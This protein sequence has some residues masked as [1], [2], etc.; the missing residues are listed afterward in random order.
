MIK[1]THL[2]THCITFDRKAGWEMKILQSWQ[3]LIRI[4][5]C[6][7]FVGLYLFLMDQNTSI[8]SHFI[9]FWGSNQYFKKCMM[10]LWRTAK[11]FILLEC[12]GTSASFRYI[13][14]STKY[15]ELIIPS[16]KVCLPRI[17]CQNNQRSVQISARNQDRWGREKVVGVV[18][19]AYFR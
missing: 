11:Y 9:T 17:T 10:W 6:W 5:H 8:N 16:E 4:G 1:Q 12:V 18:F 3:V 13:P 7:L 14:F 19:R 2:F 15:P